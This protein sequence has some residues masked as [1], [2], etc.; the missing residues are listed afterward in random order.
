MQIIADTTDFKI[1]QET[2]AAIGKFDGMHRGHKKLFQKLMEAKKRGLKSVVFTFDPP[3]EVLFGK[4]EEK[5]ITT[6]EEKR[7][8]FNKM[9]IDI[10]I[11]YPLNKETAAIDPRDF[12][13]SVLKEK[14]NLSYLVAGYDISF[15]H[16]GAGNAQLLKEMS[17]ALS[18]ISWI[19]SV[20]K[21][22]KLVLPL[23]GKKLWQEIWIKSPLF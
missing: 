20:M 14:M 18:L 12:V 15:G 17:P 2:A 23:S 11:E 16:L 4:R 1:L 3:P 10:L 6:K 9:G 19:K 21:E 5:E 7:I 13:T 8:L 22:G